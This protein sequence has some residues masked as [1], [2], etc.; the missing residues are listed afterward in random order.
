MNYINLGI[1]GDSSSVNTLISILKN[2]KCDGNILYEIHNQVFKEL[3]YPNEE[4]VRRS[5]KFYSIFVNKFFV[6]QWA[7]DEISYAVKIDNVWYFAID[8]GSNTYLGTGPTSTLR[9]R[10]FCYNNNIKILYVESDFD[11]WINQLSNYHTIS[12]DKNLTESQSFKNICLIIEK[13]GTALSQKILTTNK[14]SENNIRDLFMC[15]I[16]SHNDYISTAESNYREG[17]TDLLIHD[18]NLNTEYVFEFKINKTIKDILKGI[19]QIT[20]KYQTIKNKYN[21]LIIINRQ[22]VNISVLFIKIKNSIYASDLIIEKYNELPDEQ[23]IIVKH[24][25]KRDTSINCIL[26]IYIFDNQL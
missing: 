1:K 12:N 23:K 11:N 16:Q 8:T 15:G 17:R 26:I 22:S 13:I 9:I 6:D 10:E 3:K 21:G 19:N 2:N 25:H 4:F 5:E 18:K 24:K 20:S 7:S 14:L